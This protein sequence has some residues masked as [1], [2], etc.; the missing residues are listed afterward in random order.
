LLLGIVAGSV[1]ASV[2]SVSLITGARSRPAAAQTAAEPSSAL[3][4]AWLTDVQQG[5]TTA[6]AQHKDVLVEF[7]AGASG[8]RAAPGV[9]RAL[10]GQFVLVRL[11]ATTSAVSPGAV[12]RTV[13]WIEKLDIIDLPCAVLFDARGR[14]YAK[15]PG[16]VGAAEFTAG[17]ERARSSRDAR[18][19]ALSAASQATG[20]DR[21]RHLDAALSAV[22]GMAAGAY[23]DEMAE[24][25]RADRDGVAGLKHKYAARVA[26]RTLDGEIQGVVYPLIDAGD[27]R[28]AVAELER[29][30]AAADAAVP[31]RQMLLAFQ[32][33]LRFTLG[34]RAAALALMDRALALNPA[35]EHA[36]RVREARAKMA[37]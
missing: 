35:S 9:P 1:V 36:G 18:D 2:V 26:E 28:N 24:I 8:G 3:S 11:D 5:V 17:V 23:A 32:G 20:L 19:A 34:E 12:T 15:I 13:S 14:P 25:V 37:E 7:T 6:A 21:A 22:P 30:A 29:L 4:T 10:S 31:E 27:L 16:G 33:Q